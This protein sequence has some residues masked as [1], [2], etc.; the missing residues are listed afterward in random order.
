MQ[1]YNNHLWC[2]TDHF[3]YMEMHYTLM[4]TSNETLWWIMYYYSY[5]HLYFTLI[6][7]T[8]LYV[9]IFQKLHC[10]F[11]DVNKKNLV[12]LPV[13][14]A[15]ACHSLMTV[16]TC[17]YKGELNYFTMSSAIRKEADREGNWV[18]WIIKNIMMVFFGCM[19][20]L[21]IKWVLSQSLQ[22]FC[23]KKCIHHIL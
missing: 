15:S 11:E 16:V 6:I 19:W 9:S 7:L 13:F 1:Y 21:L 12:I 18:K 17:S 4:T 5:I 20:Q 22:N 3:K 10:I 2:S 14:A 8:I 23:S